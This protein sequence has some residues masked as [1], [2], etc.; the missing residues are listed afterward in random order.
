MP[1]LA[2]FAHSSYPAGV[3]RALARRLGDTYSEVM[4]TELETITVAI[5]D[6]GADGVWRCGAEGPEPSALLMCDIRRGRT[7]ERRAELARRLIADC[8][9]VAGV[10]SDRIKV[11]FTQHSGDEMY[12]PHLHGFNTEW[13]PSEAGEG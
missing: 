13:R 10:D 5:P 12:H 8:D 11:E 7:P 9:Q 1:S 4:E 3:K 6:M 2:L